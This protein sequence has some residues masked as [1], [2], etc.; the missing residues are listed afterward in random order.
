MLNH[1]SVS[2]PIS[3]HRVQMRRW[4]FTWCNIRNHE[5][6]YVWCKV[7]EYARGQTSL[8]STR[9]SVCVASFTCSDLICP[10]LMVVLSPF[11][12]LPKG[13]ASS[14][15]VGWF[16]NEPVCSPLSITRLGAKYQHQLQLVTAVSH[17]A[18]SPSL[19]GWFVTVR[20]RTGTR[21]GCNT[22]GHNCANSPAWLK[23]TRHSSWPIDWITTLIFR[24]S[25]QE[26]R[27]DW[28]YFLELASKAHFPNAVLRLMPGEDTLQGWER[29]DSAG[30]LASSETLGG[31]CDSSDWL[32]S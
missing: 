12:H 28:G 29:G 11:N 20:W 1:L 19:K 5:W 24:L 30:S 9:A 32:T 16:T 26:S 17:L 31:R 8:I 13:L 3:V 6:E 23:Q 14:H 2:S 25:R 10:A 18:G 15:V 4:G 27:R 7:L 21:S 22:C